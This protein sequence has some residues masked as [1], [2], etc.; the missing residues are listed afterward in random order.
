M[1]LEKVREGKAEVL[2]WKGEKVSS[3]LPVFYNP[4]MEFNRN[5][6]VACIAV[7]AGD[8]EKELVI[9]D[10]LSASGIAGI[11]YAKELRNVAEIWLNDKNPRAV[12]LVVKNL[13]LQGVR[14]KRK[15][16]LW[17]SSGKPKFV[18]TRKDACALLSQNVFNVVDID[19]YGSPSP[20]LDSLAR[21]IY[22]KGFACVTATD[23]APLCGTYPTACFRKYGI[24]SFRCDFSKELGLRILVTAIIREFAKHDKAFVPVFC[25]YYR[26]F[27]RVYGRASSR[28]S[29]ITK[30]LKKHGF[31]SFCERCGRR[32]FQEEPV[33]FC[34]CGGKTLFAGEVYLGEIWNRGFILSLIEEL[35]KRRFEREKRLAEIVLEEAEL[36]EEAFYDL[37]PLSS[38]L[39][40]SPPKTETVIKNLENLGFKACKTHFAS[41]GIRTNASFEEIVKILKERER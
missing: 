2:V 3:E 15:N 37:H 21:G 32:F 33:L 19:P 1:K 6:S 9:C 5:M 38:R 22:W 39:G 27:F 28:E 29:E 20:F 17:Q 23:T 41:T 35:G 4:E 34:E 24:K 25:F 14:L 36:Q 13:S 7:F 12:E 10:A 30:I 40:T 18:V 16:E 8:F 31:I 11:R 26:H